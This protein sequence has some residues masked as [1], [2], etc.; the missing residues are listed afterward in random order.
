MSVVAGLALTLQPVAAMEQAIRVES[1]SGPQ[2]GPTVIRPPNPPPGQR[3]AL[4]E[5]SAPPS[6]EIVEQEPPS[7]WAVPSAS[8]PTAA[9]ASP[10][11]PSALNWELV[12]PAVAESPIQPPAARP[13]IASAPTWEP[14]LPG[15][16]ITQQNIDDA[17]AEAKQRELEA[18]EALTTKETLS[19]LPIL[20]I[21]IG[22]RAY[23]Q[24]ETLPALQ[25]SI[26]IA[27]T[28]NRTLSSFSI[29]PTIFFPY[30]PSCPSSNRGPGCQFEYR[31]AA[32]LDFF[33][34]NYVSFFA[35]AG[36]A[37]NKD[38]L[39]VD[40][41]MATIGIEANLAKNASIIGTINLI[42]SNDPAEFGGLTWADAEFTLTVNFRF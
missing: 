35:G 21:G 36:A 11:P 7:R 31:I 2:Q 8:S 19:K 32:T 15:E 18:T 23:S 5:P 13:E 10:T 17:L 42:D 9:A 20:G 24:D 38:S 1:S 14:I 3:E 12:V 34:H 6:W 25:G 22:A 40:A 33:Q 27:Q 41:F 4:R 39:D 30:N 16:E 37:I 29:R 28:G 26:R